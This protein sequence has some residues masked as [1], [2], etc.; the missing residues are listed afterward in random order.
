MIFASFAVSCAFGAKLI[1][2]LFLQKYM[3]SINVMFVLFAAQ[4]CYVTIKG[5]Y[6]NI[7]KAQKRQ[8]QYFQKLML[9]VLVGIGSKEE[10]RQQSRYF[11]GGIWLKEKLLC[12][13]GDYLELR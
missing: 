6:V 8:K 9:V 10:N 13:I 7:Y 5:V 12:C 4:I 1:M 3:G 2:E 11:F